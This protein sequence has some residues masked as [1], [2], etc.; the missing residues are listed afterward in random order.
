MQQPQTQTPQPPQ[1]QL[2][3]QSST[4]TTTTTAIAA[5]G[6]TTTTTTAATTP[7]LV[8]NNTAPRTT[9]TPSECLQSLLEEHMTNVI[10]DVASV[11]RHAKR[12]RL[13]PKLHT[14]TGG[15]GATAV[16]TATIPGGGG[17]GGSDYWTLRRLH[18]SDVNMA[19][20]LRGAEPLY[21]TNVAA[22]T[23]LSGLSSSSSIPTTS[24]TILDLN[25]FVRQSSSSMAVTQPPS[26]TAASMHWLAVQGS[27]PEIPQNVVLT[28]TTTTGTATAVPAVTGGTATGIKGSIANATST[29]ST[30][31]T[32]TTT[33][34]TATTGGASGRPPSNSHNPL[35]VQQLQTAFLSEELRLYFGRVTAAV[36]STS[37]SSAGSS[38][39]K[40][41]SVLQSLAQDAGLQELVPFFI[42]YSQQ[43]LYQHVDYSLTVLQLILALLQNPFLHLEL[44]IHELLPALMTCIVTTQ[45]TT[46]STNNSSNNLLVAGPTPSQAL[47]QQ[48]SSSSQLHW[49]IRQWSSLALATACYLFQHEYVTLQARVLN[50]LCQGLHHPRKPLQCRYGSLI[51]LAKFGPKAVDAFGLAMIVQYWPIWRHELLQPAASSPL[52]V[53]TTTNTTATT[54]TATT[55]TGT[56]TADT[57]QGQQLKGSSEQRQQQRQYY[58]KN[59]NEYALIMCQQ[60]ALEAL[61][62]YFQGITLTEQANRSIATT[63]TTTSHNNKGGHGLD[64]YNV[65]GD[66]VTPLMLLAAQDQFEYATAFV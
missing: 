8:V 26:E 66:A 42:R 13:H 39:N 31:L 38:S 51:A 19:L 32:T 41:Q 22:V 58:Y 25:D 59:P 62:V 40:L 63:T 43:A 29:A 1:T 50:T 61:S 36:E 20:Q 49:S 44:H 18:A 54:T 37:H 52:R 3:P 53:D 14:T 34:T 60:A 7:L 64:W 55:T 2:Q 35:L 24:N 17:G 47:Q 33:T 9:A 27:M 16:S 46:T 11:S 10:R 48:S 65:M 28:P 5:S 57:S 30:A 12:A 45:T 23:T 21:G 4:L 6:T 56:T 15:V